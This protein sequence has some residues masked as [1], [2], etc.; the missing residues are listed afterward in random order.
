MHTARVA[1][2]AS[3]VCPWNKPNT[4]YHTVATRLAARSGLARRGL[5]RLDDL[6]GCGKEDPSRK[7]WFDMEDV[8]G[9]VLPR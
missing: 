7:W 9:R 2:D 4:W 5:I 3:K 8:N 1:G 6:L